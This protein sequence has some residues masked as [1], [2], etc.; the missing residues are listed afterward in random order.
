MQL[1]LHIRQS[2]QT[3]KLSIL[4]NTEV[5]QFTQLDHVLSIRGVVFGWQISFPRACSGLVHTLSNQYLSAPTHHHY[6]LIFE[7]SFLDWQERISVLLM[8]SPSSRASLD[9]LVA[10]QCRKELS[11]SA[12]MTMRTPKT[13]WAKEVLKSSGAASLFNETTLLIFYHTM[14]MCDFKARHSASH[15]VELLSTRIVNF[16]KMVVQSYIFHCKTANAKDG[17]GCWFKAQEG[18]FQFLSGNKW[19]KCIQECF[20]AHN[21]RKWLGHISHPKSHDAACTQYS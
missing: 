20:S 19:F 11:T 14:L 6:F 9:Y 3:A 4:S 1:L 18:Q 10:C 21:L 15:A 12:H 17:A 16:N 5:R 8:H 7:Q 2:M 13:K